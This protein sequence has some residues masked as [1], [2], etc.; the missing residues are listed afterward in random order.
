MREGVRRS[1]QTLAAIAS[2]ALAA[3]AVA[4]VVRTGTEQQRRDV[5]A[6]TAL[7]ASAPSAG[8]ALIVASGCGACH[9]I[10]GIP[11][12]RGQ[13]GPSLA[14]IAGRAIVGGSLPNTPD[15]LQAW[16]EDPRRLSP[17]TAM[18]AL[19]LSSEQARQVTAWLY[20]E[21]K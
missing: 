15:N 16:I 14:G 6:V 10:P 11:R 8:R 5:D 17:Q 21:A 20:A 9:V 4:V 19:G 3:G 13:V 18:P 12:A 2:V 1:L 7:S